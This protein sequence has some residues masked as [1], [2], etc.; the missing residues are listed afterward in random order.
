MGH[1]QS[2]SVLAVHRWKNM[3]L[4]VPHFS[5]ILSTVTTIRIDSVMRPRSSSR[6]GGRNTY[7][8]GRLRGSLSYS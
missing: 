7:S 6:G 4:F 2:L 1:C 8:L 5:S 3:I